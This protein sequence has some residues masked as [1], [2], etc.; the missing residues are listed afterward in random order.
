M[1]A[2]YVSPAVARKPTGTPAPD[3]RHDM[4]LN[5]GFGLG[6]VPI[7]GDKWADTT[8]AHGRLM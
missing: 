6:K 4:S 2:R 7:L 1:K 3:L 5:I 8:T